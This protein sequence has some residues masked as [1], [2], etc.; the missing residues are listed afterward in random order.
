MTTETTVHC[1]YCEKTV[2]AKGGHVCSDPT[3]S[4]LTAHSCHDANPPSLTAYDRR[5][6]EHGG[7][8]KKGAK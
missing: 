8:Y 5:Y 4:F 6:G 2:P 7:V 1:P 3:K